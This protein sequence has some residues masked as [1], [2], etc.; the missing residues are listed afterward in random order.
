M[1]VGAQH[2]GHLPAAG[3]HGDEPVAHLDHALF[4]R[5]QLAVGVDPRAYIIVSGV[6]H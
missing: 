6:P 3:D 4:L 2:R 5:N 1:L